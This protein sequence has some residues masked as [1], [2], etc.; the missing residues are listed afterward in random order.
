LKW[1]D[2]AL[3]FH[4]GAFRADQQTSV[5]FSVGRKAELHSERFAA[6]TTHAA[7]PP[8]LK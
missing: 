7:L 1:T 8:T 5:F 3:S 6:E 4:Y 2:S